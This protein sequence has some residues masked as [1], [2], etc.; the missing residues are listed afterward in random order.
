MYHA[1]VI[2]I[3]LS[4]YIYIYIYT[5]SDRPGLGARVGRVPAAVAPEGQALRLGEIIVYIIWYDIM[6]YRITNYITLYYMI[7]YYSIVYYST[8]IWPQT[9][10]TGAA[11]FAYTRPY[12]V[13]L[14]YTIGFRGFVHLSY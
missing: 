1:C 12:A 7:L 14:C 8:L 13:Q 6:L 4:L 2:Y 9:R 11:L 10:S 5:H 3:S